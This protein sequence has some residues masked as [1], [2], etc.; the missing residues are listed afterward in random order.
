MDSADSLRAVVSISC[1]VGWGSESMVCL[2][3]SVAIAMS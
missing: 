1:H 3:D 2:M